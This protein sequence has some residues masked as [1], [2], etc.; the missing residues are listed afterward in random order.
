MLSTACVKP[1]RLNPNYVILTLGYIEQGVCCE[2]ALKSVTNVMLH[3]DLD[4]C[5]TASEARTP[6]RT[7]KALNKFTF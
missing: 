3:R 6:A 7:A 5:P 1:A 2:L 4:G